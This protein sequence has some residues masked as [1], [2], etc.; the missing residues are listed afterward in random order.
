[1]LVPEDRIAVFGDAI[2]P[3]TLLFEDFS[4]PVSEY[5]AAMRVFKAAHEGRYDRVLRNHGTFESTPA[6]LDDAIEAAERI[7][8]NTDGKVALPA[9]AVDILPLGNP[10]GLVCYSA[11]EIVPS[12]AGTARADGREGNINYRED[13]AR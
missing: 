9:S 7:L 13:K 11:C 3:G 5:L 12:G 6:V 1:M 8:A 10:E 2:G 4:A